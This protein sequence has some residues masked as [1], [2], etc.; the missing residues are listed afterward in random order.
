MGVEI[1]CEMRYALRQMR[2]ISGISGTTGDF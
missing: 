1:R 2:E